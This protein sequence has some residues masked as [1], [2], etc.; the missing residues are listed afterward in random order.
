V[1][2]LREKVDELAALI[3]EFKLGEATLQGEGWKV[4]LKKRSSRA[5]R[6]AE[7]AEEESY[8]EQETAQPVAPAA[9]EAP[10]G[11]PVTSPMNGIYYTSPSPSAA[12]FVQEGDSVTAGQV[13][14]LI[15]A[16]KVFNE[17]V[18]PMSGTVKKIVA[19]TGQLVA[20]GE[21]LLYIG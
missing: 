13:V 14:G 21:P 4:S 2:D 6:Q 11:T 17:I 16:M 7:S 3:E 9:P 1:A 10:V 5:V 18:A 12:P 8:H 19:E 20:P 15:E